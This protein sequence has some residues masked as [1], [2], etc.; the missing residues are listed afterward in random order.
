MENYFSHAAKRTCELLRPRGCD[1]MD[2]PVHSPDNLQLFIHLNKHL[3]GSRLAKDAEVKQA[4]TSCLQIFDT[5]FF[6]A[7]KKVLEP[8]WQK[9]LMS[10]VNTWRSGVYNLLPMRHLYIKVRIKLPVSVC[11]L[12]YCLTSFYNKH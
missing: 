7:S 4:V 11:L 8:Q 12:L 5:D 3:S 9:Y 6:H 1:V 2:N 10:V